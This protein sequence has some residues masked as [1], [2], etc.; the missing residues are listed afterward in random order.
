MVGYRRTSS[1]AAADDQ[2]SLALPLER[3]FYFDES[4]ANLL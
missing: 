1:V 3:A 2:I 4:G